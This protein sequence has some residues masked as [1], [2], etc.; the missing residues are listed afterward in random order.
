MKLRWR[1]GPTIQD[2]FGKNVYQAHASRRHGIFLRFRNRI[3]RLRKE[4]Q[5]IRT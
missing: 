4:P 1:S 2:R 5:C 3:I